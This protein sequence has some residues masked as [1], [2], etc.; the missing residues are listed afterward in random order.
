MY[1]IASR[2]DQVVCAVEYGFDI[3]NGA[4][5]FFNNYNMNFEIIQFMLIIDPYLISDKFQALMFDYK[6]TKK[7][8]E[9]DDSDEDGPSKAKNIKLDK[10]KLLTI[11]L[12]DKK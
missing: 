7:Q 10:P 11:T 8:L 3:F 9:E 2:P 5:N 12:L 1:P 6:L 4:C